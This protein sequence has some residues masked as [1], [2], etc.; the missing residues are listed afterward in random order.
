MSVS[1][2]VKW[3]RPLKAKSFIR[4]I[5]GLQTKVGC[6]KHFN[7]LPYSDSFGSSENKEPIPEKPTRVLTSLAREPHLYD[8]QGWMAGDQ[9]VQG[10]SGKI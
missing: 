9:Q 1:S 2:M 4:R 3:Q 5:Y 7:P 6:Q 10:H 8:T